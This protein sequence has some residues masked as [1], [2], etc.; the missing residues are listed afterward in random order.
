MG[1]EEGLNALGKPSF[2]EHVL[3]P[4]CP[5]SGL[6]LTFKKNA[7]VLSSLPC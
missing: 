5:S 2:T 7:S 4:S 6:K 3:S 1:G